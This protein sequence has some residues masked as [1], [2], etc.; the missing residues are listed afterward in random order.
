MWTLKKQENKYHAKRAEF[1]G[2]VYASKKEASYAW[3]LEMR[4]KA[5]DIKDYRRQVRIPLDVN[6]YHICNY[7]IDFV[8]TENDNTETYT[9]VKGFSTSV[10]E[11][12]WKLCEALLSERIK[13]GEI[14]L[15][16]VR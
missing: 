5:K 14:R 15:L 11:F 12:K 16:V 13:K 7:I 9:E 4:K 8:V 1:N 10:W 6:G 3:E 2:E